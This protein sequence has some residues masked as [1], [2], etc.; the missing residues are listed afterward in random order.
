MGGGLGHLTRSLAILSEIDH[1]RVKIRVL[2]SSRHTNLV[3]PH[4][5]CPVDVLMVANAWSFAGRTRYILY[6]F[7]RRYDDQRFRLE[8]YNQGLWQ[9]QR[10]AANQKAAEWVVNKN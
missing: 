1:G 8:K 3:A 4:M 6:P 9:K 2:V 10:V 5:P 7:D